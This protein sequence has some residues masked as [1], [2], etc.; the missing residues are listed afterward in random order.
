MASNPSP[1][2]KSSSL[3]SLAAAITESIPIRSK[4]PTKYTERPSRLTKTNRP[5]LKITTRTI[6]VSSV[7]DLP[8]SRVLPTVRNISIFSSLGTACVITCIALV[9]LK[10]VGFWVTLTA[11][12]CGVLGAAFYIEVALLVSAR[13]RCKILDEECTVADMLDAQ[14]DRRSKGLSWDLRG[15]GKKKEVDSE[16]GEE[17]TERRNSS[18]NQ[19]LKGGAPCVASTTEAVEFN[20][21]D[22]SAV[23]ADIIQRPAPAATTLPVSRL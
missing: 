8:K 23:D 3:T 9:I 2:S 10:N 14:R 17:S 21:K 15:I 16:K 7:A 6:P 11:S 18:T 13:F 12:L 1:E 5:K 22:A 19:S 4:P 20:E